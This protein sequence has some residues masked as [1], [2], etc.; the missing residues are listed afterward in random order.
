MDDPSI[1]NRK[2][3]LTL[4]Q[5]K[6]DCDLAAPTSLTSASSTLTTPFST[7][8]SDR[9]GNEG[10][11]SSNNEPSMEWTTFYKRLKMTPPK[12]AR[13]LQFSDTL[14][15]ANELLKFS[16]ESGFQD[17]SF[18][19][20][21]PDQQA[22]LMFMIMKEMDGLFGGREKSANTLIKALNTTSLEYNRMLSYVRKGGD[23]KCRATS[24]LH[25]RVLEVIEKFTQAKGAFTIFKDHPNRQNMLPEP[26]LHLQREDSY[27]CAYNACSALLY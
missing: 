7:P 22:I 13:T 20:L 14:D 10:G 3:G 26:F 8:K 25:N 12:A 19:E 24:L 9:T 1:T 27:I 21:T 4:L 5:I 23:T 18:D 15:T 2:E 17:K 11:S 16:Q 6:I